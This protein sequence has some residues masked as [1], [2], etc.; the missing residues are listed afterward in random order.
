MPTPNPATSTSGD[1]AAGAQPS[2]TSVLSCG[3]T[4]TA[5][6]HS[7]CNATVASN[8]A[9]SCRSRSSSARR[10]SS[11]PVRA[12]NRA[13][14]ACFS[15][16]RISAASALNHARRT[17]SVPPSSPTDRSTRPNMMPEHVQ[18]QVIQLTGR[19]TRDLELVQLDSGSVCRTRLAIENMGRNETG[20]V[21]A[22]TFGKAVRSRRPRPG[23]GLARRRRWSPRL[24]PPGR[25]RRRQ[26]LRHRR[27]RV[28]R[29][30]PRHGGDRGA[31]SGVGHTA[32][33]PPAGPHC[34]RPL[35]SHDEPRDPH[36]ARVPGQRQS[37][38]RDSRRSGA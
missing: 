8:S 21:D 30:A 5:S 27:R 19:L 11:C 4:G 36:R 26:P 7:G 33:P 17:R 32:A 1:P 3:H 15:A 13:A 34:H 9:R 20:Y 37:A 16:A 23:Q 29:R 24:P 31:G 25:R 38:K 18:F 14:S 22:S 2:P 28:P 10:S 12:C 6:A 35:S